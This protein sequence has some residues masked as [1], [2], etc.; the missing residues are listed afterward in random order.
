MRARLTCSQHVLGNTGM[1]GNIPAG[2]NTH[3]HV[4]S[5]VHLRCMYVY[6]CVCVCARVRV[7]A[8]VC[9]RVRVCVCVC[10]CV[11][12]QWLA[13]EACECGATGR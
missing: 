6:V 8:C 12:L 2:T 5:S 10:A 1:G 7:C 3:R 13:K 9:V 4:W 11:C